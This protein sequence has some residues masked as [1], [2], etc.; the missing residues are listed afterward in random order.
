MHSEPLWTKSMGHQLITVHPLGG[1]VMADDAATGVVNDRGEVFSGQ[2]G[3]SATHRGLH[4]LDGS[5]VPR[6]VDTNPSLTISALAERAVELICHDRSWPLTFEP[7]PALRSPDTTTGPGI[8]FTERMAGWFG[9]GATTFEDGVERGQA[10]ASPLS[11]V[12]TIDVPSIEAISRNP[13]TPQHFAGT[14]DAPALSPWPLTI[15]ESDFRLKERVASQAEEWNMTYRM[16]L[17]SEEGNQFCFHGHKV[18]RTGPLWRGW[19]ETTTLYATIQDASGAEIGRGILTISVA[20]LLKQLGSMTAINARRLSGLRVKYRFARAFTGTFLPAYGGVLDEAS[21]LV[22]VPLPP[23][24]TLR[25]PDP[26]VTWYSPSTGWHDLVD[27]AK[28]HGTMSASELAASPHPDPILDCV[29]DDAEL[30]LTRF[31]GGTKG[32]VLLAAGFSMRAN[33]FAQPTTDTTMAEALVEAGYDVWLFDY[34]ASIALP[35]STKEFTIDDIA[36]R[37]WPAAV[38]EVKRRTGATSVQAVG[39]CVGSVTILMAVLAGLDGIRSAVCSQFAV[40][41][42][43]SLLNRAKNALHLVDLFYYV[44]I[45]AMAPERGTGFRA[46][47]IDLAAG[48]LPIPKGEACQEPVCRWLNAVFGLTHAHSQLNAETHAAFP[49]T[50]G[51]GQVT[52]LR[53][54]SLITRRGKVVDHTGK[55]SYLPLVER[56]GLPILFIQGSE[57]YIFKPKGMAKTLKWLRSNHDP[58]LFKLLYLDG[59]AHLDGIVGRDAARDVFPEI[60]AHLDAT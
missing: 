32:P 5:I 10:D 54:L 52:P 9:L 59:Y 15:S 21:R 38:A 23:S 16:V 51:T 4:V 3:V 40:H 44:G 17:T 7:A 49:T 33:S 55:N 29:D 57:N 34:R 60:I 30:M 37:D 13:A 25:L 31:Q 2:A 36:M 56:L 22:H 28:H 19:K 6:P 39:H 45:R 12:V 43:T 48:L 42:R 14:V 35:S 53:Q 8:Q 41:P 58:S 18:I 20:D 26:E 47:A 24:R 46:R 11:F 27:D 50:F 1:C